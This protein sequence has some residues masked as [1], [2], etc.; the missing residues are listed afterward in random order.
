MNCPDLSLQSFHVPL[1]SL[2]LVLKLLDSVGMVDVVRVD[3]VDL[4]LLSVHGG[5]CRQQG[6]VEVFDRTVQMFDRVGDES[7]CSPDTAWL[8]GSFGRR[9]FVAIVVDAR[10]GFPT[11]VRVSLIRDMRPVSGS[12][13]T[14]SS[15]SRCRSASG[16]GQRRQSFGTGIRR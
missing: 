6:A 16:L 3:V 2:H 5:A 12:I 13:P 15:T 14:F 4:G 1:H 8:G 7:A 11:I 9:G 10:G